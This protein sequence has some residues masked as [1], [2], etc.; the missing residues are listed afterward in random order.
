MGVHISGV[1][2]RLR[3]RLRLHQGPLAASTCQAIGDQVNLRREYEL[4]ST[5]FLVSTLVATF[6]IGCTVGVLLGKWVS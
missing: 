4:V 1:D 2:A 3:R 6:A 5:A